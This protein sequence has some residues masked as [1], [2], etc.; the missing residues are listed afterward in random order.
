MD[1]ILTKRNFSFVVVAAAVVALLALL[2][3]GLTGGGEATTRNRPAPDFSVDLFDVSGGGTLARADLAGRPAVINFWASWCPP[4]KDE[5]PHL[6]QVWQEYKS[7]GVIF[8]GIAVQDSDDDSQA[9]I[10]RYGIT[11]LNGPDKSEIGLD[12]GMLGVPETFF[13]D[14][15]GQIV[16]RFEGGINSEQLRAFLEEVLG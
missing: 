9:F 14:G 13:L 4:C 5:A 11:Y 16:R 10:E 7:R 1:S 2:V 15:E 3:Y 6:E 8:L 12:F